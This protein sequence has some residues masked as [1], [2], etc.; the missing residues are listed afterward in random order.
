M[1]QKRTGAAKKLISR[2]HNSKNPN[3]IPFAKSVLGDIHLEEGELQHA[4][5]IYKDALKSK[6]YLAGALLGLGKIYNIEGD[7]RQASILLERAIKIRP[8]L[9]EAYL[10]LAKSYENRNTK[11][12][13][14]YYRAFNKRS[15][16]D[17]EFS[18]SIPFTRKKII[19][20]TKVLNNKT[21][22]NQISRK[23]SNQNKKA[24]SFNQAKKANKRKNPR[25]IQR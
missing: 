22:K 11:K 20:L 14:S 3:F 5:T 16:N 15:K 6:P 1:K 12:S 9:N 25:T 24:R 7:K 17:P 10:E 8:S 23:Q 18:N 21:Q 19:S 4:K 2:L 13:L